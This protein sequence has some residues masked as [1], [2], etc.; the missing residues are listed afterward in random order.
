MRW[1]PMDFGNVFLTNRSIIIDIERPGDSFL[2]SESP[3]TYLTFKDQKSADFIDISV[4]PLTFPVEII[5]TIPNIE[6]Y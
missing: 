3:A 2:A 4:W 6:L 5:K 1:L